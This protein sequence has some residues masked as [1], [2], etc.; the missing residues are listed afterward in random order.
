MSILYCEVEPWAKSFPSKPALICDGRVTTYQELIRRSHQI[1][2]GLLQLG[3]HKG[4]RVGYLGRNS[5][6][7]FELILGAPLAGVILTP[8][9]WRLTSAEIEYILSDLKPD[10]VFV[11]KEFLQAYQDAIDGLEA[12]PHLMVIDGQAEGALSLE[13]WRESQSDVLPESETSENDVAVIVYTS[14]TTG[15]PKGAQLSHRAFTV[16]RELDVDPVDPWGTEEVTSVDFPIFHVSGITW[17]LFCLFGGGV[18]IIHPEF[19]VERILNAI[20]EYRLTRI[21]M[22]PA[23]LK[24]LL[25]HIEEESGD[26][27]S[28]DNVRYGGS[29]M[30][31]ELLKRAK[32]V[33]R[34]NFHQGYGMTE[35]AGAITALLP[36]DHEAGAGNRMNSVG[37]A[38]PG[39]E[40]KI[41]GEDG[42][43]LPATGL[44]EICVKT[45]SIMSGYWHQPEETQ[46]VLSEDG[47]Y[48]TGDIGR[49][50]GDGYLFIHD[51]AKDMI[52]SG[53]ENIYPAEIERALLECDGVV[54][55]AVIGVPSDRWGEEV[56]AFVIRAPGSSLQEAA[57]QS[58]LRTRLASYKIPKSIEL[59]QDFPRT[60]S[61]KVTKALIRD[62]Y[63]KDRERMV[64]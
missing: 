63:W 11:S 1:A 59:V 58:F 46:K 31:P 54:E 39:V 10:A 28:I 14:G 49:F 23:P 5:D 2:N 3:V 19:S 26:F 44:G 50:D 7:F 15:R 62:Q 20:R 45:P 27:S 53:G 61:G 64:N 52:V 22:V 47:W 57:I 33:F 6:A 38:R 41:V 9:N 32:R 30:N 37:K 13:E 42:Q 18:C 24:F 16:L 60:A 43:E 48:R 17:G 34:C 56:K 21:L 12:S 55:A 4:A 29:P 35:T 25:D 8:I 36:Q 51:R 40:I